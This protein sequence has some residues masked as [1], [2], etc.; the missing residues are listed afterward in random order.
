MSFIIPK[1]PQIL[2]APMLVSLGGGSVRGFGRGVGGPAFD[3]PSGWFAPTRTA[4]D[5]ASRT[6]SS[7]SIVS[8]IRSKT[9]DIQV[10]DY[11]ASTNSIAYDPI[12]HDLWAF[13][14]GTATIINWEYNAATDSYGT[15]MSIGGDGVNQGYNNGSVWAL[16]GYAGFVKNDASCRVFKKTVSGSTTSAV[17][18]GDLQGFPTSEESLSQVGHFIAYNAY[19]SGAIGRLDPTNNSTILSSTM[20][21]QN[22]GDG[23]AHMDMKSSDRLF[24]A[25]H[26]TSNQMKMVRW[27]GTN[28]ITHNTAANAT[29]FGNDWVSNH[30]AGRLALLNHDET[31]NSNYDGGDIFNGYYGWAGSRGYSEP[32]Y[33]GYGL[34]GNWQAAGGAPP[35]GTHV[36]YCP[37]KKAWRILTAAADNNSSNNSIF[38]VIESNPTVKY[39]SL[40]D[41]VNLPVRSIYTNNRGTASTAGNYHPESSGIVGA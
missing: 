1:K 41:E 13:G 35:V 9:D 14:A 30:M 8:Y 36:I 16:G 20:F 5:P 15:G 37:Y 34:N 40:A 7:T 17:H 2:Y 24:Y 22:G 23:S 21:T 32:V 19:Q 38:N 4:G 33:T 29:R 18:I 12:T 28:V 11:I 31:P 6:A 26:G 10:L 39:L 25:G 27:D 3:G